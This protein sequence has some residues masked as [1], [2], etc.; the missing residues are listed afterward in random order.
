[1]EGHRIEG[2]FALNDAQ[3]V[4]PAPRQLAGDTD[5]TKAIGLEKGVGRMPM[6]VTSARLRRLDFVTR[7]A[8]PGC[9]ATGAHPLWSGRFSDVDITDHLAQFHYSADLSAELG[10]QPFDLVA[11]TG[12][13]LAYHRLILSDE[14]LATLYGRWIDPA[15]VARFEAAHTA[16]RA[17]PFAQG[18]QRLKTLMRLRALMQGRVADTTP[19]RLMDFGCGD[20]EMLAAAKVLGMDPI[21]IDISTSRADAARGAGAVV[22]PDLATF[23]AKGGGKVHAVVLSQ[24]L[25]HVSDPVGLLRALALRMVPGGV[26]FVA[27]PDCSGLTRPRDFDGFHRLQPLEHL[28]AFTPHTL[29]ETVTRAGFLPLRRPM[30]SLDTRPIGVLRA[31]ASLIYQPATT[32]QFF[33]RP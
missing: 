8:C 10:D 6:D 15:Q 5:L 4:A 7:T 14:G 23:D 11:C 33:R 12:C 1:M 3:G 9:G 29:R 20:G 18:V 26:L 30:A 27:V 2:P 19:I 21:G 28:N 17:N 25:E 24:V 22:L 31:L 16:K 13:G 32:D